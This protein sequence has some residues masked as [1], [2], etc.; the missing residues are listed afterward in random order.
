MCE[1]SKLESSKIWNVGDLD[2][3]ARGPGALNIT[4]S[5]DKLPEDFAFTISIN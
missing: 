1:D 5:D 4:D 2:E 3:E